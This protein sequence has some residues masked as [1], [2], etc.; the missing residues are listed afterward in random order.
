VGGGSGASALDDLTDVTLST[1]TNGQVLKYNGTAWVNA[2]ES[3]GSGAGE[4]FNPFL[5]AG[6]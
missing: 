3:G 1:P 4:T 5:L 2:E 6:M